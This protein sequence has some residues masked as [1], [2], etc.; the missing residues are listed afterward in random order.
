MI[1][2]IHPYLAIIVESLDLGYGGVIYKQIPLNQ[3]LRSQMD[4]ERSY[5][6]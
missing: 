5:W 2:Y 4:D 3:S 6:L 1:K